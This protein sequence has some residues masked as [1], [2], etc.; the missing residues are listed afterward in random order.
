MSDLETRIATWRQ[1]ML[2]A[3]MKAPVPLDELENHLRD[4][5]EHHLNA[6]ADAAVAFE[7][8]V[9]RLGAP[10]QLEQEFQQINAQ[11][12]MKKNLRTILIVIA[13][14]AVALGFILPVLAKLRAGAQ[15][16]DAALIAHGALNFLLGAVCATLATTYLLKRRAKS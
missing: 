5:V 1:Q 11:T 7:A 4:A 10:A 3:G 15:H 16:T 12:F 9:H 13:V 2:A 6:G 14:L 8:A